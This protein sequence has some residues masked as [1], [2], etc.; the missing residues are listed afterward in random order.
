MLSA[1]SGNAVPAMK[2]PMILTEGD[3]VK[4]KVVAD[5]SYPEWLNKSC[6]I[7]ADFEIIT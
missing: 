4:A 6:Q 7:V 5:E 2:R 1:K 3:V